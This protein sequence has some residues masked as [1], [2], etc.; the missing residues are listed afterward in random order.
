MFFNLLYTGRIGLL[1]VVPSHRKCKTYS[2]QWKT[3][4]SFW[5]IS[6]IFPFLNNNMI[7]RCF[8]VYFIM[9]RISK[10]YLFSYTLDK[11]RPGRFSLPV[12]MVLIRLYLQDTIVGK[13]LFSLWNRVIASLLNPDF[14]VKATVQLLQQSN[15]KKY[16]EESTS[17]RINSSYS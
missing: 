13:K 15:K 2:C 17:Q 8:G 11:N 14:R 6:C 12:F 9:P 16:P 5:I 3:E 4:F 10:L 1:C 7:W